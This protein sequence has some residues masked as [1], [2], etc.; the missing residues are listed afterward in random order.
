MTPLSSLGGYVTVTQAFNGSITIPTTITLPPSGTNPGSVVIITPTGSTGVSYITVTQLLSG[1]LT[2]PTTVT[3][4][5]SGTNPGSVV[6]VTPT[7]SNSLITSVPYV[8]LTLGVYGIA[9]TTTI[10]ILPYGTSPGTIM[11]QTPV[12]QPTGPYTTITQG[13]LGLLSTTTITIPPTGTSLGTII[14]ETP[15]TFTPTATGP[16][17]TITQAVLGLNSTATITIPPTGT[18]P[19]TIII[20]TPPAAVTGPYVTITQAVIGLT[21]ILTITIPPI[22]TAPGTILIETPP[23][24]Y[25]TI[26]QPLTGNRTEATTF[27]LPASGTFPGTVFIQT[28]MPS[29]VPSYVTTV[30]PFNGTVVAPTT[31]TIPPTGTM[32]GT[33][34]IQTP[35]GA[36]TA[37]PTACI[38]QYNSLINVDLYS[39]PYY[40]P[41]RSFFN[42]GTGAG[43][44]YYFSQ[45]PLQRGIGNSLTLPRTTNISP[46]PGARVYYAG[47]TIPAD[48]FTLV[49]TGYYY[50]RTTGV[51]RFCVNDV[52]DVDFLYMGSDTAFPCGSPYSPPRGARALLGSTCC[53][54]GGAQI[55]S[56]ITLFAGYFYPIRSV[57]GNYVSNSALNLLVSTPGAGFTTD[58]SRNIFAANC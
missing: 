37:I 5:P 52:D 1:S 51:Y 48:N 49:W 43:P 34:V 19:G 15:A 13:V 54:V 46:N 42:G 12:A 44:D 10:T 35:P 28:P 55:C 32:P 11:I 57:F 4:P 16:Y 58:V 31:I 47:M 24:S 40:D 53:Y 6:I 30:I 38:L 3:V 2:V 20:E 17:I 36:C 41:V 25:V 14:I 33:V 23:A 56:S 50:A 9:G 39:D 7:G 21:G 22:G 45:K 18:I 8:T 26:T 27:T 29:Y